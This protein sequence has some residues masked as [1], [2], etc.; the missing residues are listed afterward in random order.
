MHEVENNTFL[1]EVYTDI[2]LIVQ[3]DSVFIAVKGLPWTT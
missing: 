1:V 2:F 3:H